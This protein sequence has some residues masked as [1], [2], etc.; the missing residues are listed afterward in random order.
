M[1]MNNNEELIVIL[2]MIYMDTV[3]VC[4][5]TFDLAMYFMH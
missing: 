2:G 1:L 5:F 4:R 3:V